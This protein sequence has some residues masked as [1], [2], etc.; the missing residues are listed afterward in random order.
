MRRRSSIRT[1]RELPDG[2][3]V[4]VGETQKRAVVRKRARNEIT[5]LL[6]G[7]EAERQIVLDLM[8]AESDKLDRELIVERLPAALRPGQTADE[9]LFEL[10]QKTA[11]LVRKHR[12]FI[13]EIAQYLVAQETL[14]ADE[15]RSLWR[16]WRPPVSI[17][18]GVS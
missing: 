2:S 8:M 11:A 9:L 15:V 5:V 18:V 3:F 1:H 16:V 4:N 17:P 7:C 12:V 13:I 6:A 14:R 10:E